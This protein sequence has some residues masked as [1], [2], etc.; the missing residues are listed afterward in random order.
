LEQANILCFSTGNIIND[1]HTEILSGSYPAIYRRKKD[2]WHG[3]KK[4][5][6]L[7]K[8]SRKKQIVTVY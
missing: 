3:S 7:K 1:K 2:Q 8:L 4:I 5:E 6:Q